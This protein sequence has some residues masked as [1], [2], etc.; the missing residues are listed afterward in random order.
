MHPLENFD[1]P[2]LIYPDISQGLFAVYDDEHYYI[3]D[4]CFMITH[5]NNDIN[6]LKALA[7]IFSSDLLNFI[8]KIS[9]AL[10]GSSGFKLA[11]V[12]VKNLPI[13]N[14]SEDN[15]ILL[16]NLYDEFY[17][18]NKIK[19][20]KEIINNIKIIENQINQTLYSLYGLNEDEIKIIENNLK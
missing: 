6:F 10:L 18:A 7:C 8:F 11:K 13:C 5:S 19:N 1:K 9:G 12:H 20:E 3:N 15:K 2:K 4:R 14:L 17:I 16:A